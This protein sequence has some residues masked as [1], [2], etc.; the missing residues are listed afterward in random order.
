MR[1]VVDNNIFFSLMNP[2]SISSYI[3]FLLNAEFSAPEYVKLEFN[4]HREICLLKSKLSEHEFEISQQEVESK[5]K[6]FKSFEYEKL[7]TTASDV[8]ADPKDS[9]YLALALSINSSIW[10][11]DPHFKQQSLVK[12]FTTEELISELLN[13]KV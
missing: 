12:V 6:F 7:L 5:I 13:S 4:K 2:E 10:S 9:P 1:L 11:N 3:F 8:A